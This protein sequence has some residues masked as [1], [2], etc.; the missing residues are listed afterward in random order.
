VVVHVD[1]GMQ[2][3]ELDVGQEGGP[4]HA[5]E[6]G[7][8][9][10]VPR[11]HEGEVHRLHAGPINN[12]HLVGVQEFIADL[13]TRGDTGGECSDIMLPAAGGKWKMPARKIVIK[14]RLASGGRCLKFYLLP[15]LPPLFSLLWGARLGRG[16]FVNVVN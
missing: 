7:E 16:V 6:G 9:D 13:G 10:L 8:Y 2:L 5:E 1:G 14:C 12:A 3:E 11:R 4:T 15:D